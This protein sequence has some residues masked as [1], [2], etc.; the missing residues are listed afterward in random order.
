MKIFKQGAAVI[1]LYLATAQATADGPAGERFKAWL[2]GSAAAASAPDAL[3]PSAKSAI[4]ACIRCHNG[5][6]ATYIV[7]KDADAPMQFAE[8]GMQVN[9]PVG[10]SY[11]KYYAAKSRR[12][13]PR[14]ALDPNIVLVDGQVICD[15]CHRRK[16]TR[17]AASF[18][19][20]VKA[21]HA[22]WA[23]GRS[24]PGRA[25]TCS[26]SSELTVGPTVTDL[27]LACHKM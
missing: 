22:S 21:T 13:T 14:S 25:K 7:V 11:E 12:Y 26:A 9:H 10:M 16:D 5:V 3:R 4:Q 6:H 17:T 1:I 2:F 27:C 19:E 24:M 23:R 18:N 20:Q 8:N 15:S